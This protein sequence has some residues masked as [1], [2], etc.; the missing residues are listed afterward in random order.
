M[1]EFG[2]WEP[3]DTAPKD[4]TRVILFY[5]AQ[6][7]FSDMGRWNVPSSHYLPH[8]NNGRLNIHEPSHWMPLPPAPTQ[9]AE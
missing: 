6:G 3:I 4:G 5:P 9:E 1:A 7:G 8:W 2:K